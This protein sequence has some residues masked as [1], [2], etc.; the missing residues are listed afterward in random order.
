MHRRPGMSTR[1]QLEGQ[2]SSHASTMY[3]LPNLGQ[4][5]DLSELY[6]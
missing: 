1:L 3:L 5:T 6:K 4:A 2:G